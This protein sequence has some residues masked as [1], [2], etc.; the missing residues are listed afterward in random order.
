MKV[1]PHCFKDDEL[2][3]F[4]GS[5]TGSETCSVCGSNEV[6]LKELDE[7]R[8]FFEELFSHIE[9]ATDGIQL[10]KLVRHLKAISPSSRSAA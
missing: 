9:P 10:L 3:A 6:A 2:R 4:A 7:F 5:A 1:C 8:E